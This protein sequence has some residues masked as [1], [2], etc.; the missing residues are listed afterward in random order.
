MAGEYLVNISKMLPSTEVTHI[1][2]LI[3][4]NPRLKNPFS[5]ELFFKAVTKL[6]GVFYIS[7]LRHKKHEY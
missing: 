6:I 1:T 2:S 4:I 5:F 7:I 3:L